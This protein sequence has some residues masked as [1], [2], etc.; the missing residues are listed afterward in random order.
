M[1]C[2]GRSF[3]ARDRRRVEQFFVTLDSN[4]ENPLS[5]PEIIDS[6]LSLSFE[7][8][9]PVADWTHRI[10]PGGAVFAARRPWGGAA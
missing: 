1:E 5:T 7:N 8:F 3:S 2:C 4:D 6:E 9:D 10:R